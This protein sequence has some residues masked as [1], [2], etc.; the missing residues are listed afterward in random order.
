MDKYT[1]NPCDECKYGIDRRDGSGSDRMCKICEFQELLRRA[2]PE[3]KPCTDCSGIIYRQTNSGKIV[4]ADQRCTEKIT[5]PCYQPDGDGCAYQTSGDGNEPIDKCQECPLCYSDKVRHITNNPLTLD[6]LREMEGEPVWVETGEISI[7]EQ[8]I[9]CWEILE[10]L[11]K[12]PVEA[13]WFTRRKIGFTEIT[14]GKTWLAYRY[15]PEE[16]TQ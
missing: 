11:T 5:P 16:E 14:Y 3:N 12:T 10:K 1:F 15:K 13:F 6:E 4:P 8:I 7:G 9:G 2:Q